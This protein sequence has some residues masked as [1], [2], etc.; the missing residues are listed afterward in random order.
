MLN[1]CRLTKNRAPTCSATRSSD[2]DTET[3]APCGNRR[4]RRPPKIRDGQG[5]REFVRAT[6]RSLSNGNSNLEEDRLGWVTTIPAPRAAHR[7]RSGHPCSVHRF[8]GRVGLGGRPPRRRVA[9]EHY[10]SPAPSE[11]H[12]NLSVYAA[13]ASRKA[14]CGTRWGTV[15]HL[16]DTGLGLTSGTRRRPHQ[17]ASC[18]HLLCLPS[19]LFRRSRA[20]T[21]EGSQP[22]FAWGDLARGL[23]PYPPDYRTAFASSL[24][25]Y[26]PSHRRPPCGGPTP[27]GGRRAYHVP[28]TYHGWFR[29]CLFAGGSTAT[30]GEG[31]P[32]A[33]GHVPFGSSLSAPLAC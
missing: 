3:S 24:L 13:Q 27:K 31:E 23:N 11:R 7:L 8:P 1:R 29:L 5:F 20:E 12:V 10:C 22:A 25:L 28:R 19:Q 15:H 30:A 6:G 18:R 21:P 14:P 26:P 2:F 32:P 16:H 4:R 17:Q 9:G 33:P